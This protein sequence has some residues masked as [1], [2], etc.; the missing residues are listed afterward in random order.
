MADTTL[1]DRLHEFEN[2][3]LFLHSMK[4][5]VTGFEPLVYTRDETDDA[6]KSLYFILPE[7][8]SYRLTIKYGV[9]ERP[10]RNLTYYQCVMR[11]GIP[12][13][14]NTYDMGEEV[15]ITSGD[16]YHEITFPAEKLPGGVLS[17]GIYAASSTFLEEGEP[18]FKKDWTL[19]IVK[20]G[21][22]PAKGDY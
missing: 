9:K 20:K 22:V 21:T 16:Q 13:R 3:L 17:R 11:H 6:P 19:E 4:I 18:I 7:L 15:V 1:A 12:V 2:D 8:S 10:L 5:D 14:E